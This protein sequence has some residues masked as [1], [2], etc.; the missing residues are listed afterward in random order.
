VSKEEQKVEAQDCQGMGGPHI[1]RRQFVGAA[2]ATPFIAKSAL[3][4]AAW[5]TRTVRFV[6]P[7]SAGGASDT[8]ARA[9]AAKVSEIIGQQI[10]IEN[11]T[12]GNAV[13]A[14]NVVL[15]APNDG[16]TYVWD[17]ANQL[18]NPALVKNLPFDYRTAFIP[19]TLAVRAP[20]VLAV[21]PDFPAK[22]IEQFIEYA[23]A[24]PG[25]VTCGT[26]PSGA[27]GHLALAL[28]QQRSGLRLVH[29]PYRGGADVARDIMGSQIDCAILT[30]STARGPVQA[31]KMR[32]LA[33]T[34]ASRN[35]NYPD[36]PTLAEKG[37]P[38]YDMDDWFGLFAAAG[39][40]SSIVN[41]LHAA[42]A[43]A[44]RD[45]GL[46]AGMAPLG[47]VPVGSTPQEFSA[48]LS[49][50]RDVLEKLIRDANITIS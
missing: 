25:T 24:R 44:L 45:P 2:L 3:A 36:I 40:P 41:R 26:P 12:G 19:I 17:A 22:T 4:D 31:G 8:S 42:V 9:V 20:Q 5:P 10:I 43:K 15:Q 1:S 47:V 34:S 23:R 38:G 18:T 32:I 50:Q 7:F 37:F 27:M 39:T 49:R 29:V 11:R 33:M 16:Y 13:V 48:W 46:L 14:A 21:K 6:V 35:P 28:L 30:T